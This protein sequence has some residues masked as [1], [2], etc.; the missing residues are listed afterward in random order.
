MLNNIESH[1]KN[2]D[3]CLHFM[4]KQSKAELCPILATH[5][6]EL[7]HIDYLIIESSKTN[8]DI[9]ILVV[10]DHFMCYVQAFLTPTQTTRV[11][12]QM[13]GTNSWWNMVFQKKY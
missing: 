9:N 8:K 3:Q 7:I 11:V 1:I 10:T 13:C 2:C 6:M 4:A 5:P 12:A